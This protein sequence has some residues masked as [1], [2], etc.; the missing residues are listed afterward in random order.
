MNDLFIIT[1]FTFHY[2]RMFNPY[3]NIDESDITCVLNG[4]N[5]WCVKNPSRSYMTFTELND[6]IVEEVNKW[7]M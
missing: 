4:F 5:E 3:S 7:L 6:S 2:T 1:V